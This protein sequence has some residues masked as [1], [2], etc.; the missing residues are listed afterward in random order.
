MVLKTKRGLRAGRGRQ[1]LIA[2]ACAV[3]LSAGTAGATTFTYTP[4]AGTTAWSDGVNWSALPVSA[5]DTGLAFGTGVTFAPGQT[6]VNTDDIPGAGVGGR[7][8]LNTMSIAGNGPASGAASVTIGS[9]SP[10]GGLEFVNNGS[11]GPIVTL[12]QVAGAGTLAYNVTAPINLANNLTVNGGGSA[13][14]SVAFSGLITG[15]GSL[16]KS[17]TS[18]LT[19]SGANTYSGGTNV[20]TGSFLRIGSDGVVDAGNGNALVSGP[21]G[22]GTL[23][24]TTGGNLTTAD[25]TARTIYNPITLGSNV[26]FGT[27]TAALNGALT[28]GG[29]VTMTSTAAKS[30]T[31]FNTLTLNAPLTESGISVSIT[32]AGAGSMILNAT[33]GYTGTTTVSAGSLRFNTAG[34]AASTSSVSIS[35]ASSSVVAGFAIDQPFVNK[36]TTPSV[37]LL[38]IAADSASNLDFSALT[39]ATF[40]VGAVGSATLSGTV[41]VGPRVGGGGG[42]L[43]L[44]GAVTG[45]AAVTFGGTG[46]GTVVLAGSNPALTSAITVSTNGQLRLANNAA[47]TA[48]PSLT[49]LAGGRVD[50]AA[51]TVVSGK[52][53][54]I[55]GSGPSNYGALNGSSGASEW[56]GP[57]VIG[58]DAT[59]LGVSATTATLNVSGVID[60]GP[61]TFAVNFRSIDGSTGFGGVILSGANTWGGSTGI[62]TGT[63]RLA[64]GD[65]RLPTGTTVTIGANP[66]LAT[67]TIAQLDLNGRNQRVA[68]VKR[69]GLPGSNTITNT[70]SNSSS[71]LTLDNTGSADATLSSYAFDG[72]LLDTKGTVGG[73][74]ALVKA[75]TN[76]VTLSGVGNTYAGGTTVVGGTLAATTDSAFGNGDVTALGGTALAMSGGATS[77]YVGDTARLILAASATA[78]LNY[79]GTDSVDALSVNGGTSFLAPGVYGATAAEG[80]L[81]L[82]QLTGTGTITVVPEPTVAGLLGVATLGLLS[83]RRRGR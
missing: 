74:L 50:L 60:D 31:V 6:N 72:M 30:I 14:V 3:G 22:T 33:S 46:A 68:G 59:R 15:S 70:L 83:R 21:V 42:V 78:N 45:P 8:Q 64:G 61:N 40:G 54:T 1:A 17:S 43:T 73:T 58:T 51:G 38:N 49:V 41:N 32:K 76:T 75:G 63:V 79:L 71:I 20:L 81:A 39:G 10:S 19:L 47:I 37:G 28:F 24:F 11:T 27:S 23:A 29:A 25:L 67:A 57:V 66:G 36:I 69:N 5:V 62:V 16:T 56:A 7:F 80:I 35:A 77:N 48:V 44:A 82:P 4:N 34:S 26:N 53:V 2:G 65:D 9:A 55:N 13:S 18:S 52:T 12:T